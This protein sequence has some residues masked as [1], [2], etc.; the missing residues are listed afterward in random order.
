MKESAM[1]K[2]KVF[3]SYDHSEDAHYKRLL[4]AW[5]ANPDF[6][7]DFDSRGPDVP[8]DSTAAG[9]IKASLTVK[10]KGATHL[11]VL[12][13][14]VSS[15]SKWINWEISRA[16]ESD[17]KLKLAAVKLAKD[18]STPAGLL[19]AGTAWATS[20]A[21]DRIVESLKAAKNAY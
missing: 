13:G 6:D 7:F 14:A 17:I 18:N 10:M 2:L 9:P 12:V 8:I 1:A 15:K 3:V 16:K 19:N 20:F 11:L 4:Q 5:D 21:R